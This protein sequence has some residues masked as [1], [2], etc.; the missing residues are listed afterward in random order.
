[1]WI[2]LYVHEATGVEQILV[3]LIVWVFSVVHGL[4]NW[5]SLPVQSL[6]VSL[7]KAGTKQSNS[8]HSEADVRC[9][10]HKA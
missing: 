1:M 9:G 4:K 6:Q 7:E 3:A 8:E 10:F 2:L 5:K